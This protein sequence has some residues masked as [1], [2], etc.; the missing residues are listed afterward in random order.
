MQSTDDQIWASVSCRVIII[1]LELC[2]AVD[3]MRDVSSTFL[4]R[5]KQIAGHPI[6]F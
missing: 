1:E 4:V 3:A 2:S 5:N 6:V